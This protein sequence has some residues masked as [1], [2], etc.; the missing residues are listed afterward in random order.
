LILEPPAH[1]DL[2]LAAVS[3][4]NQSS[5]PTAGFLSKLLGPFAQQRGLSALG[6]ADAARI[7]QAFRRLAIPVEAIYS[8][9]YCRAVETANLALGLAEIDH[10]LR[11]WH[12]ELADTQGETLPKIVRTKLARAPRPGGNIIYVAHNYKDAVGVD[13]N[14]GE[15]TVLRLDGDRATVIAQVMPGG[16]DAHLAELPNFTFAIF[17]LPPGSRPISLADGGNGTIWYAAPER[18]ELGRLN[19]FLG[20]SE[21]IALA[22]GASPVSIGRDMLE[23]NAIWVADQAGARLL[24]V[25]VP[26]GSGISLARPAAASGTT[27]CQRLR[28]I[29]RRHQIWR[30]R[31]EI[32][33]ASHLQ[34]QNSAGTR[35]VEC[36]ADSISRCRRSKLASQAKSNG[37]AAW[38]CRRCPIGIAGEAW[39][40]VS[41]RIEIRHR[42]RIKS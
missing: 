34:C 26:S 24:R 10:D 40:S 17:R 23:P 5:A 1:Y 30:S 38:L 25:S 21:R 29:S 28:R 9:P 2:S 19:R 33:G 12:G 8:S 41:R 36:W 6:R 27:G 35:A 32:R 14:Q 3:A 4:V 16:W 11:L 31:P 39:Q 42:T 22:S 7:G 18:A 37:D 20:T 13:L 15:A